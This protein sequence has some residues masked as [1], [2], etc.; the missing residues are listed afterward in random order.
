MPDLCVQ[1]DFFM[2]DAFIYSSDVFIV[3]G[4]PDLENGRHSRH[5]GTLTV[6]LEWAGPHF[7]MDAEVSVEWDWDAE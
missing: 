3:V 4:P 1:I 7:F 5:S 6:R 2:N